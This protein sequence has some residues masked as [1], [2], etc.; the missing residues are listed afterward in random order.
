[1]II[2][3]II[4]YSLL[5]FNCLIPPNAINGTCDI[6]WYPMSL[7]KQ[8]KWKLYIQFY[9]YT[10]VELK[11]YRSIDEIKMNSNIIVCNVYYDLTQAH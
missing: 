5:V 7:V 4:S 9:L 6:I 2:M 3:F 11:V 8:L 1:M 10:V